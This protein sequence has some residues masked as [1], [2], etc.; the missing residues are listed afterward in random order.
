MKMRRCKMRRE[1][2]SFTCVFISE[3]HEQNYNSEESCNKTVEVT[4]IRGAKEVKASFSFL[5]CVTPCLVLFPVASKV[6]FIV[7]FYDL[8]MIFINSTLEFP[9]FF[10]IT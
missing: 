3:T 9:N 8:F 10:R 6:A 4:L 2:K 5:F 7:S 1:C